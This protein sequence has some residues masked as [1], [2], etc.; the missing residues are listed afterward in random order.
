MQKE[1]SEHLDDGPFFAGQIKPTL[2]DLSAYPI[3]VSSHLMG[4]KTMGSL[5]DDPVLASWSRRVQ[6]H[7]PDNPLLVP[8]KLLMP[9]EQCPVECQF[10]SVLGAGHLQLPCQGL[11]IHAN[12]HGRQ[13]E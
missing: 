6:T 8:N 4:M 9:L 12:T 7:L 1:F 13:L 3:V 2:A 5:I 11:H 10:F